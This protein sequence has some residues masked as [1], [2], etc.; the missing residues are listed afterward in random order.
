MSN[1]NVCDLFQSHQ[2]MNKFI[3]CI[4][5]LLT[6]FLGTGQSYKI[7]VK[8][9]GY[10]NDTLLLGYQF[11]DKQYIKDTTF[12]VKDEFIFQSKD[13]EPLE[14]GIYLVVTKPDNDYFQF[15]VDYKDQEF[16]IHTDKKDINA[17]LK[18]KNSKLNSD[19]MEYVNYITKL[20]VEADSIQK[21]AKDVHDEP[22]TAIIKGKLNELDKQVSD[23]QSQILKSQPKSILS[24]LI[25]WSLDVNIPEMEGS[26]KEEKDEKIFLYYKSHYFDD[27]D[28]TDNRAVRLP[29]FHGKIDRYV[30]KLTAQIPDSINA[31]LDYL[32]AK[33]TPGS[34][35]YKYILSN[36]L[37]QYGNSKYVGMDGVYVHLA[38]NYYESGK[39]P[40][41]DKETLAKI[42]KD[43]KA[44]KP[45]LIDKI[46][47]NIRVFRR[48]GSP[49]TLHE[50]KSPYTLLLI[51]A[52]DCPHCK[53]SMPGL[54]TFYEQYKSKGVEIVALCNKVS[55]DEPSCWESVDE[56]KM[57]QW[58][59]TSDPSLSSNFKLIYDVK[60]TPQIYILDENKKILTKK[61]AVEQLGEVM[62]KLI[63]FKQNE[64]KN[65]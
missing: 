30:S 38:E 46:A 45:L 54:V 50:I 8:I 40:W 6:A 11:G 24:T 37:N 59:N 53:Q 4:S 19:F 18:F 33:C 35:N 7:K 51:W 16:S 9:D 41:I 49:I 62:E 22:A 23:K 47:P 17:N 5:L 10:T 57:G 60:S 64:S 28:F 26:T 15:M 36:S 1:S 29:L 65:K 14:P 48:D 61:I 56:L 2:T 27:V 31:A 63:K 44:L 43:A 52:P 39:A 55:K 13:K 34:E 3:L 20:R 25:R 12:R 21:I 42:V 32:L 58:I